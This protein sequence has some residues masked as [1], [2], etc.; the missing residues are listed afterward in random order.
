MPKFVAKT[1]DVPA[2]VVI[3]SFRWPE[4]IDMQIRVIRD[5]CGAVPILVSND[6]PD[7]HSSLSSICN[8]HKDI[9]L[10]TNHERIGH[11]GGDISAFFKGV[12]W[13][14]SRGLRVV[15]KLS[16][17]F[18]INRP[19]WLQDSAK[20]LLLSGL[21]IGSRRTHGVEMYDLR[22]EACLLDIGWWNNNEVLNRITPRKMWADAPGGLAAEKIIFR[23]VEDTMGGIYYPWANVLGEDRYKRDYPDVLW[24]CN[25]NEREYRELAKSHGV[26]LSPQ[27]HISGWQGE[28]A[29][30]KYQYG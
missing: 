15:C 4:L 2:G 25:T 22:T 3:G 23:L 24:H 17:R 11:T 30:G 7:S 13:G 14:A 26:E 21:P 28:L 20:E 6:D 9:F 8:K 29:Q 27:F 5:N 1:D 16:Q 18:V 12:L 19:R 10:W